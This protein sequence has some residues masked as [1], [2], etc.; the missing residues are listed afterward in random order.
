MPHAHADLGAKHEL[1]RITEVL[2]ESC[3]RLARTTLEHDVCVT[4]FFQALWRHRGSLAYWEEYRI[5]KLAKETADAVGRP[6]ADK[7]R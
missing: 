2:Y 3:W 7:I 4:S 1:H 5:F 6:G